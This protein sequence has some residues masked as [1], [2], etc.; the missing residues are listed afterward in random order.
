[1][2]SI[3]VDNKI[4]LKKDRLPVSVLK[5]ITGRLT[6]PNP[7]FEQGISEYPTGS[8][9]TRHLKCWW[10]KEDNLCI[11]KGFLQDLMSILTDNGLAYGVKDQ[12]LKMPTIDYSFHGELTRHQHHR[13][14]TH[15]VFPYGIICE[16]SGD[17]MTAL[18]IVSRRRQPF[19]VIVK[20]KRRMMQWV[21]G[22]KSYLSLERNQIGIVGCGKKEIDK[23]ATVAIDQ[24]LYSR[25]DTLKSRVGLV[26]VDC[27]DI[28][29]L[30]IFFKGVYP[31]S[32]RYLLAVAT[33]PTRRDGLTGLMAAYI[34]NLNDDEDNRYGKI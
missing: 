12:T 31:F 10:I 14:M 6:F 32:C 8:A 21:N 24:S 9:V 3:I 30:K 27:C 19:L 4:R 29:N 22:I 13:A 25:V 34:G 7:L 26:V 20:R 33:A 15:L 2:I 23:I 18:F 5:K 28:V 11:T 17:L 16:P 1:M